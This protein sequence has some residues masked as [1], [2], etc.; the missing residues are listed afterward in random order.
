MTVSPDHERA[1]VSTPAHTPMG[2]KEFVT[3][4]AGLMAL[5]ALAIDIMLPAL[6][7]I[8]AALGEQDENERQTVL[9]AYLIGFGVG[10]LLIGSV[11]DRFGRRPVLLWGLGGYVL[12]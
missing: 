8:G 3:L 11:S 12:S 1:L 2:F 4:V 7:Q 5:N 6:Q 9:S 10:Q